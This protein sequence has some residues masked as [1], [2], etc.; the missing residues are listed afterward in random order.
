MFQSQTGS[1]KHLPPVSWDWL[2][3]GEGSLKCM[4]QVLPFVLTWTL[5]YHMEGTGGPQAVPPLVE[6]LAEHTSQTG[7][8][9]ARLGPEELLALAHKRWETGRASDDSTSGWFPSEQLPKMPPRH[10]GKRQKVHRVAGGPSSLV[11]LQL[12]SPLWAFAYVVP[13]ACDS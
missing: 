8:G 2:A 7:P 5:L 4:K 1:N 13:S 3:S 9:G 6:I 12:L 11:L 10:L